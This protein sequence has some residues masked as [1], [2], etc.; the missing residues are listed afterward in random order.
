LGSFVVTKEEALA[1]DH[2]HFGE[3]SQVVGPRGGVKVKSINY[4]RNGMTRTWKTR[5]GDFEVPLKYGMR[6]YG[7][8]TNLNAH[9]FHTP[10]NCPL[11]AKDV[12]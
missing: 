10:E 1:G 6:E 3:C 2:F 12:K 7:I 11:R 5:K 9:L 8:L 4:R